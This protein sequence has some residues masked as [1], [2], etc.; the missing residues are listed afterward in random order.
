MRVLLQRSHHDPNRPDGWS[1]APG[2]A[3]YIRQD[4]ITILAALLAERGIFVAVVEGDY[5]SQPND[6]DEK[7]KARHPV[8]TEDFDL[9]LSPHYEA[10]IHG[11]GGWFA[12]RAISSTTA[13]DDDWFLAILRSAYA[14][15]PGVPAQHPEW[16]NPN[17]TDYYAF[18][19]TSSTTPGVLIE[20]GVGAPG[21]PDHDWLRANNERIAG[22]LAD[23][24]C[25]F[26]GV[27]DTLSQAE[28]DAIN[29]HTDAKFTELYTAL[30]AVTLR[31]MRGANPFQPGNDTPLVAGEHIFPD[32][33]K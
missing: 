31:Q 30:E 3:T 14:Q 7:F 19:C 11:V 23:A 8:I 1:G 5:G 15:I 21:A 33:A 22:V 24:I 2:E 10:N 20:L 32:H 13:A 16:S 25:E 4:I 12:G 18:R 29:A 26:L 17:V 27:E 6:N 28:V 9:F